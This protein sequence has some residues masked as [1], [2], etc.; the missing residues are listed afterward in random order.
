MKEGPFNR[1]DID[2][3]KTDQ[4]GVK[5]AGNIEGVGLRGAR[6]LGGI[7]ANEDFFNHL[8]F[9]RSPLRYASGAAARSTHF[10]SARS[11]NRR[12]G[13]Q[14]APLSAPTSSKPLAIDSFSGLCIFPRSPLRYAS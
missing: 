6:V 4:R 5:L 3:M 2:H 14:L 1:N 10:D 8:I 12:R 13:S 7:D 11:P 9:P